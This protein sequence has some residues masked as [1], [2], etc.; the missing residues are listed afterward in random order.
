M[1]YFSRSFLLLLALLICLLLIPTAAQAEDTPFGLAAFV[2]VKQYTD[3]L[4]E[5]V[6]SGAWYESGVKTVYELSIM[7]GTEDGF[8][9]SGTVTWTQAVTIAARIHAIYNAVEIPEAE[10][11][12]YAKYMN[13]ADVAGL[14]PETH[15]SI[16]DSNVSFINRE[17]LAA[18]FRNILSD[19]D[20]PVINDVAA[21]DIV[22]VNPLY[23][24]AVEDMYASGIFTGKDGGAFDP[25]GLTTR[26]EIAVVVTRLLRPALRVSRDSRSNQ[27]MV[28]QY[29]NFLMGG[30]AV[31]KGDTCYYIMAET[32][33]DSD[34][35]IV[36]FR[37]I[38]ERTDAG[39][40]RTLYY[41]TDKLGYLSLGEDGKL[42]F[43]EDFV[44][45]LRLD[46]K[47]GK[48]EKLYTALERID[49]YTLYDGNIYLSELLRYSSDVRHAVGRL[50]QKDHKLEILRDDL[51]DRSYLEDSFYCFGGKLYCVCRS[52]DA[53][54]AGD[55]DKPYYS[56]CSMDLVTGE[57]ERCID[58]RVDRS[59][60][61][62]KVAY[63]GSTVWFVKWDE[64]GNYR[65]LMRANL[66]MP[67]LVE[68]VS[69]IPPAAQRHYINL[70]CNAGQL[71]YQSSGGRKLWK[72]SP[73]GEFTELITIDGYAE[74]SA[75][76]PQ[77]VF[78]FSNKANSSYNNDQFRVFTP[79]GE[80]L[81]YMP[82]LA[83]P[84]LHV[85]SSKLLPADGTERTAEPEHFSDTLDTGITRCFRTDRGDFVAEITVVNNSDQDMNLRYI[86]MYLS[87]TDLLLRPNRLTQLAEPIPAGATQV[88]TF[89][90]PAEILESVT[91]AELDAAYFHLWVSKSSD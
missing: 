73:I 20:L 70:Y 18:L 91:K 40:C 83:R 14:L 60:I 26:A 74:A 31:A 5:D 65:W 21:T 50:N 71:Y 16:E 4:F 47:S 52:F 68:T 72:V 78:Q 39:E 17:E 55:D 61:L 46:P 42:Y 66:L 12:W 63:D 75:L 82:F 80:I 11:P 49:A 3:G 13:Y 23:R 22:D 10:G 87:E 38:I 1:K 43:V 77:G 30:N 41:G 85:G 64:E 19:P 59:Y 2:A 35:N 29:G 54:N 37:G 79:N 45:L 34:D 33:R 56:L 48:V 53:L 89:V 84:Y 69:E 8:D 6:T 7:N 51:N 76:T 90:F 58:Y 28:G 44:R 86:S 25:T 57:V 36:S 32:S 15:P 88:F 67:E 24:N 27:A 81:G 9:P 62:S